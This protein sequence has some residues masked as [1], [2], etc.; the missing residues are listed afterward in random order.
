MISNRRSQN[1]KLNQG[2]CCWMG[3]MQASAATN[4]T[5]ILFYITISKRTPK[6]TSKYHL[7][8]S[9]KT[10]NPVFYKQKINLNWYRKLL[11]NIRWTQPLRSVESMRHIQLVSTAA[12]V[13]CPCE[14]TWNQ[15]QRWE[16]CEKCSGEWLIMTDQN[17][18]QSHHPNTK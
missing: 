14:G 5:V 15:V 8:I 6:R 11:T 7:I 13:S 17:A 10:Q 9:Q 12:F 3:S 18:L 2:W 16:W 1:H 4:H